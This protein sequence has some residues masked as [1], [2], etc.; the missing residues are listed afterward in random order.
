MKKTQWLL[1]AAAML[2]ALSAAGGQGEAFRQTYPV[3][4]ETAARNRGLFAQD[5]EKASAE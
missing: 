3:A 5:I 4:S 2:G 1:L